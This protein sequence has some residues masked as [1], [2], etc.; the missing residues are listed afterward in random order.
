MSSTNHR[1]GDFCKPPNTWRI[2]MKF[3]ASHP[4]LVSFLGLSCCSTSQKTQ[5]LDKLFRWRPSLLGTR[6]YM[7]AIARS[8]VGG[9]VSLDPILRPPS[10]STGLARH[11]DCHAGDAPQPAELLPEPA[12]PGGGAGEGGWGKVEDPIWAHIRILSSTS[13]SWSYVAHTCQLSC[14]FVTLRKEPICA[15]A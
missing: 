4:C 2:E 13:S 6:S 10:V 12:A 1:P 11:L 8:F 15:P 14:R 9:I 7:E 3:S 5:D